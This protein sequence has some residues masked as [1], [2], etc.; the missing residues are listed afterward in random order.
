MSLFNT[1]FNYHPSYFL[2]FLMEIQIILLVID[3]Y[4]RK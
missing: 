1:L 2:Y 3:I 4:K